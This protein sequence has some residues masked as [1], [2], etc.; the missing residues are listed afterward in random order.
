[1]PSLHETQPANIQD[2]TNKPSSV[3]GTTSDSP[4]CPVRDCAIPH[5]K[6][7]AIYIQWHLLLVE[8]TD[9][10]RYAR[11]AKIYEQM[12][13][14]VDDK[15][16]WKLDSTIFTLAAS[17]ICENRS[18]TELGR[19][20]LTA[21]IKLLE[22][23]EGLRTIQR[24]SFETGITVL[25]A[26]VMWEK[27]LV[28]QN[29]TVPRGRELP[30]DLKRYFQPG[31][32]RGAVLKAHLAC[33]H[34]MNGILER[35]EGTEFLSDLERVLQESMPTFTVLCGIGYSAEKFGYWDMDVMRMWEAIEFVEVVSKMEQV[36]WIAK[37]MS[38]WLT[39]AGN[40]E[41]QGVTNKIVVRMASNELA[42]A[43][44]KGD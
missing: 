17:A 19:S 18:S 27:E 2:L 43:P 22:L 32:Y 41:V 5:F 44:G 40:V 33:L 31:Q 30:E 15:S 37:V 25:C 39:G 4:F 1:M 23:R 29:I 28:V 6:S 20:H 38:G 7:N 8:T 3:Y 10:A 12:R 14:L 24:M 21:V 13:A 42:T 35:V 34:L 26:L 11:K 16:K 36:Q 9:V